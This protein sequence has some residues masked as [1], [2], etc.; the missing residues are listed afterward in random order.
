MDIG[1]ING[2]RHITQNAGADDVTGLFFWAK[3][4]ERMLCQRSFSDA[5][6]RFSAEQ[7]VVVLRQMKF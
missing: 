2:H 5:E 4:S 3:R 7:I 6:K 1:C